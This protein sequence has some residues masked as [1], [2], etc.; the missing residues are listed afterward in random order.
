[1][2]KDE[3]LAVL[4]G[5]LPVA[6]AGSSPGFDLISEGPVSDWAMAEYVA[7]KNHPYLES[8]AQ[9]INEKHGFG[10]SAPQL[11]ALQTFLYFANE[12]ARKRKE[13]TAGWLLASD[14]WL[15]AREGREVDV[16][17]HNILGGQTSVRARVRRVGGRLRI[18]VLKSR[19]RA[20]NA[21]TVKVRDVRPA[22]T[23]KGDNGIKMVVGR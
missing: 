7:C 22:E 5:P 23:Y 8:C 10:L 9:E 20:Y 1:M 3:T 2:T 19:S 14:E 16:L 13:E 6:F 15:A 21:G 11:R 12:A 17:G 18:M 4:R